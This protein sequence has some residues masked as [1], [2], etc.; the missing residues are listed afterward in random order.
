MTRFT[1]ASKALSELVKEV[2]PR[3]NETSR[4]L[5]TVCHLGE[6]AQKLV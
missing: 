3:Q 1:R 4:K 2:N 6:D 5:K